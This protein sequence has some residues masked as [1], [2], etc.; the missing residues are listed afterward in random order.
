MSYVP[1]DLP[2]PRLSHLRTEAKCCRPGL[3]NRKFSLP[4][5]RRGSPNQC[6]Q[7]V[8]SGE[9]SSS[10]SQTASF[11]QCAQEAKKSLVSMP[12]L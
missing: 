3:N 10:G 2:S 8:V 7:D 5:L 12:V 9:D 6:C 4:V 1:R 11:P